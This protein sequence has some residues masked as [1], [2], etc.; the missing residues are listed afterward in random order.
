MVVKDC[1]IPGPNEGPEPESRWKLMFDGSFNY[2]GHGVGFFLLNLNG[3]YIPFI[4]RLCFDITNNIAEYEAGILGIEATIG[5][6]IKILDICGDL[7]LV[8]YQFKGEW[9]TR[10]TKLIPYRAYVVELI[11]Y[12]DEI[13]FCHIPRTENQVANALAILASIYRVRFRNEAPLIQI[14]RKV[15]PAY[16]QLVEEEG[17]GKPWFHDIKC[18]LQNP[19]YPTDATTPGK[20]TLRKLASKFFLRNGVLYKRNHDMVLLRCMDRH[21]VNLLIKEI[22]EESFR[23]HANGNATTKKILRV[24]YY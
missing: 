6:R 15:E 14:E 16:C 2:M 9:E 5:L 10:D 22:H 24:G 8:I 21:E 11:K 23:T 4:V 3:G 19:E 17:D 18:Y 7:A 20:E 13:T 1:E 12:F